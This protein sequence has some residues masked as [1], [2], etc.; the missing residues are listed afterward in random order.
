MGGI[1]F[2]G[3]LK[4]KY[5]LPSWSWERGGIDFEE[6]KR[7]VIVAIISM[8]NISKIL[9]KMSEGACGFS[10]LH[11]FAFNISAGV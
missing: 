6:V 5:A 4:V 10:N 7:L 3:E 8:V 11:S 1:I 2:A 9:L